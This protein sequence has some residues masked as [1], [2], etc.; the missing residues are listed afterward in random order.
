MIIQ[1]A[2]TTLLTH[3][4]TLEQ[5]T[6]LLPIRIYTTKWSR[7]IP[8]TTTN[9]N[10]IPLRNMNSPTRSAMS[11]KSLQEKYPNS[12]SKAGLRADSLQMLLKKKPLRKSTVRIE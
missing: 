10:A 5:H 4:V 3:Q 8:R 6:N 9:R 12:P 11:T 2:T 1:T 7:T